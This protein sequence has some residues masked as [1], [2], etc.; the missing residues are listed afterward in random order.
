MV[1]FGGLLI[2]IFTTP[3]IQL[4]VQSGYTEMNSL[5]AALFYLLYIVAAAGLIL[6]LIRYFRRPGVFTL[7]EALVVLLATG[8]VLFDL[9]NTVF[10]NAN[11]L[12]L[13]AAAGI[14][15]AALIIAKNRFGRLRNF[16][17]ITSSIGV[18]ILIGFNGFFLAYFLM[19]LI[20]VYDYV[21]VFITK[22]MI[23]MA[24]EMSSRN[25]A[26]LIG[27]TDV[28]ALPK[29]YLSSSDIR[30]LK[31]QESKIKD[32]LVKGLVKEGVFPVVSQVQLGTGDLALPLMLAVSAYISFF[33]YFAAVMIAVGSAAGM[34]FTMYLLKRYKVALPAI[35]P[36]F[37]FIN[38]FLAVLF[39]IND[40]QAYRIWFGFLIVAAVTL[41]ALLNKLREVK[42]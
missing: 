32:P 34:V 39:A 28:E 37:A 12:Y 17:A 20:A 5:E 1:Q 11:S 6:L 38:L 10:P 2:A 33:S 29:K 27:S 23:A 35:P 25:L 8:F 40:I 41:L 24:K 26:F 16:I 7:M 30:E 31:K 9:L 13:T 3:T 18:G 4:Y 15:T 21:A 22:H 14:I 19:L 36:L 42:T